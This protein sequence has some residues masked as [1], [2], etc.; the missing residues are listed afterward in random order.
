MSPHSRNAIGRLKSPMTSSPPPTS[1]RTP[2]RPNCDMSFRLS[3]IAWC[4]TCRSLALPC[5]MNRNAVTMRS[6]LNARG[7]HDCNELDAFKTGSSAIDRVAGEST[8]APASR[9]YTRMRGATVSNPR[10]RDRL[11]QPLDPALLPEQPVVQRMPDG[12]GDERDRVGHPHALE[13]EARGQRVRRGHLD[14]RDAGDGDRHGHQHRARRAH[15]T[16]EHRRRAVDD[17]APQ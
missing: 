2:C 8:A 5:T 10:P 6:T 15:D 1:S 11:H 16:G 17:G 13:A 4:G 7:A 9:N 3:N 14:E 12:H